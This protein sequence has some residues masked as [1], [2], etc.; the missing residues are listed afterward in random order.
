MSDA[1]PGN[2]GNGG[3][4]HI[5]CP[6]EDDIAELRVRT[7]MNDGALTTALLELRSI[8]TTF[9][10]LIAQQNVKLESLVDRF[11][12][13]NADHACQM[14]AIGEILLKIKH[15]SIGSGEE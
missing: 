6:F 10:Q 5:Q 15:G 1:V 11:E 3:C 14:R 8:A 13:A 4:L 9:R 12:K 7:K 2:G